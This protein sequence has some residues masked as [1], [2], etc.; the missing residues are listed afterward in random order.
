MDINTAAIDIKK[1]PAR[2]RKITANGIEKI[3][4]SGGP[5][6]N[7]KVFKPLSVLQSHPIEP[8]KTANKKV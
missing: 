8:I 5:I 7:I 4:I 6:K 1:P 2:V 3:N